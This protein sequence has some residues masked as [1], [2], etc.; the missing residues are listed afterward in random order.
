MSYWLVGGKYDDL[1]RKKREYKGEEV[2]KCG[3]KKRKLSLYLRGKIYF[4]EID[5][6][7]IV[8]ANI[9]PCT[10]VNPLVPSAF[11]SELST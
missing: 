10:K 9:H 7:Q 3:K 6:G 4:L 8:W 1:L 2:G 5:E 11:F